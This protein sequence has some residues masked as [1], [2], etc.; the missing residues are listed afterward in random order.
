M[1][2]LELGAELC[3]RQLKLSFKVNTFGDGISNIFNWLVRVFRIS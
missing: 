2:A 1:C 3:N